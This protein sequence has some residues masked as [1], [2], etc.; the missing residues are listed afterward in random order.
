MRNIKQDLANLSQ[1]SIPDINVGRLYNDYGEKAAKK[2]DYDIKYGG[3]YRE[4]PAVVNEVRSILSK[5]LDNENKPTN[6]GL[7]VNS[8][9]NALQIVKANAADN[10]KDIG[11]KALQGLLEKKWKKDR[12]SNINVRAF[13]EIKTY[14]TRNYPRSI[15]GSVI[16]EIGKKGYSTLPLSDLMRIASKINSQEDYNRVIVDHGL[17]RNQPHCIKARNFILSLINGD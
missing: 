6:E 3:K 9:F 7:P 13:E 5:V 4:D 16:D 14:Y 10:K 8:V 12:E 1:K 17:D 15:V 11:L 2:K